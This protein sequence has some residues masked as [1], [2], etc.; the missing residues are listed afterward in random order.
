MPA[1]LPGKLKSAL[2]KMKNF[3]LVVLFL[4]VPVAGAFHPRLGRKEG[5]EEKEIGA[6]K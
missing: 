3:A 4:L 1:P 6:E 5:P 2:R